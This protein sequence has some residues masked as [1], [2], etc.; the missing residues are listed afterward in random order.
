M[1]ESEAPTITASCEKLAVNLS[2]SWNRG[3]RDTSVV[4]KI[5]MCH[6]FVIGL[7]YS[8]ADYRTSQNFILTVTFKYFKDLIFPITSQ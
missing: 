8:T 7:A 5:L 3:G 6:Q 1:R 2:R 4:Y